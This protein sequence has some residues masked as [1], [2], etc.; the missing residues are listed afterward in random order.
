MEYVEVGYCGILNVV[1]L[2]RLFDFSS[3]VFYFEKFVLLFDEL[4]VYCYCC[5]ELFKVFCC[6]YMGSILSPFTGGRD[7]SF[8]KRNL[9]S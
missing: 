5:L 1:V 4:V 6:L 2:N 9:T 8:K 3:V 7:H